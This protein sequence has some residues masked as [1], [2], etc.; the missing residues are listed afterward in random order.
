M[1][2]FTTI[3]PATGDRIEDYPLMDR[4]ALDRALDAAAA[5]QSAWRRTLPGER[6]KPLRAAGRL[7]RER[8]ADY[9]R[10]MCREMGKPLTQGQAESEKCA[11]VCDYYA[12]NAET[13]L[14][15]QKIVTDAADSFVCFNPLGLVLAIMPW[16]YPFW[17]VLRFAAP[18]MSAG[19]AGLL[20]HSPNVSGCALALETL[21]R[22]AGFPE[23]LFRAL[24]ID[25]DQAA[26]VIRDPRV[27]AVSLTGS[28]GAGRAVAATAGSVLKKCVLELGGS[29]PYVV[30][31]DADLDLAVKQC[32]GGRFVNAGQSCVAAK[33]WI[34][35]DAVRQAFTD[36]ALAAIRA[37]KLGD[38]SAAETDIGPMARADLRDQLHRQVQESIERGARCLV[39]GESSAGAGFFYPPTLLVEV[40]PGMPAYHDELF[41]PVASILPAKDEADAVR[42]ANDTDYGLGGAVFTADVARGRRLAAEA[43]DSGAVF[44][45][46]Q[47]VSDPRLPFGGIKHSGYGREL[48]TFGIREF[49]NVKAVSVASGSG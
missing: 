15:P 40:R 30:L 1:K 37:L 2:T 6:V 26:D 41:G 20:K 45:N 48:S 33:R 16:N 44:V 43:I 34:V 35:V 21:F 49:V 10:L 17:Q 7:L 42:I 22:D 19:N 13:F 46:R 27:A 9:A 36:K 24:I 28:V 38:P 25:T 5:A 18:A 29:D 31:A 32:L 47:L 8:K 14:A 12:D 3:N 11:W 39:G 4:A 23:D